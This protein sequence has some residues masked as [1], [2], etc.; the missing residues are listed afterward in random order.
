MRQDPT[1]VHGGNPMRTM[2]ILWAVLGSLSTLPGTAIGGAFSII[3]GDSI[4]TDPHKSKVE[5]VAV[6]AKLRPG[7]VVRVEPGT[8]L[9]VLV[10]TRRTTSKLRQR[11]DVMLD[12]QP[13]KRYIVA[14][15]HGTALEL[16]W[17]LSIERIEP[18]A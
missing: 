10:S 13:C 9:L 11:L 18:I 12:M 14:A 15:D 4:T 7:R 17:K 1:P 8:H 3:D 2:S 5:V 6:D 16:E